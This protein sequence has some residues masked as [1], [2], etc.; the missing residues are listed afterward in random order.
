MDEAFRA[1]SEIESGIL[2]FNTQLLDIDALPFG[3][4]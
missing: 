4:R 1:V 2:W 3:G